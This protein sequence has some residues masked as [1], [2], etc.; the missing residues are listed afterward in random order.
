[1]V[2]LLTLLAT[3]FN[4]SYPL[5]AKALID[6]VFLGKRAE[7]LV[8]IAL[9]MF[10]ISV[11]GFLLGALNRYLYT[12]VSTRVLIDMRLTFYRHV[13]QLSLNFHSK[14]R[15]GEIM[16]R[17]NSDIAEVQWVATDA[18]LNFATSVM[19]LLVSVALLIW[20][21]WRLFLLSSV[22][23]PLGAMALRYL[24]PRVTRQAR[25]IREK[26]ADIA[27]F[28]VERLS[29]IKLIQ[30][31]QTEEREA[32]TLDRKNREF[33]HAL[34]RFQL[35][36]SLANG[37]PAFV[38]A[39]S[40]FVLF[41]YGGYLVTTGALTLGGLIAFAAYQ[42][43][44]VGPLQS[45]ATLYMN[46]Q[47]AQVALDRVFEF[48]DIEPEIREK[49]GAIALDRVAG[50]V[51][52][53]GVSAGYGGNGTVLREV[54]FTVPAGS[55]CAIVGPSGAGKT[56]LIDLLLRFYDPQEGTIELDG[57]D[58]RELQLRSLRRHIAVVGQE[59]VLF[60]TTIREN[61]K[62]VREDAT[63]E[64][65]QAAA[66]AACIHEF[67]ETLPQGYDTIVGERG[68][69]LSAGQRQRIA[70]ARA[71]LADPKILILDEATSSLDWISETCVRRAIESLMQGRTTIIITHR[72]PAI[73]DVDQILVLHQGRIV[74][75]GRHEE[76]LAQ[77]GLY[78]KL[79]FDDGNRP[80]RNLEATP[81]G[82]EGRLTEK[83]SAVSRQPLVDGISLAHREPKATG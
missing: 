24:H 56:T 26:N 12:W 64:E 35:L 7:L 20:L 65:V 50:R 11:L 19:A 72:L 62:Y 37:V 18:L 9:G 42:A 70:I 22:F 71:I 83:Q 31:S 61:I 32:R 74:Q 2:F 49:E 69:K 63:D 10:G 16:S 13:Q 58:L 14:T 73:R 46:L 44:F 51:E 5:F 8:V 40:G 27:S 60:H 28:L 36:A 75:A 4:L 47:R 30:A 1:L 81:S 48:M 23:A 39:S 3:A 55:T 76:L 33:M 68:V 34:L 66:R 57:H 21:N 80:P 29:G 15:V 67:I 82:A 45:L 54:S 41:L 43:R 25:E 79:W 53:K 38:V 59:T 77:E 17:I 6:E 78:R 52:F